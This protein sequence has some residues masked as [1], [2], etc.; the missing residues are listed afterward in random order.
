[1]NFRDNHEIIS[2]T[3]V[4][5]IG[6]GTTRYS[7]VIDMRNAEGC[8]YI[9]LGSTDF[10]P[11]NTENFTIRI[12]GS[13]YSSG[14]FVN[15]GTTNI[16]SVSSGAKGRNTLAG[17]MITLDVYKPMKEYIRFAFGN[18]SCLGQRGLAI[19]YGVR[20]PGATS[21]YDSTNIGAQALSVSP[22]S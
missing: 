11:K 21:L 6:V 12:Q 8:Q 10:E 1:M 3:G 7:S 17:K 14:G 4:P 16:I 19:L 5:S 20:R 2:D 13:T 22:S 15:L 18:S 9:F